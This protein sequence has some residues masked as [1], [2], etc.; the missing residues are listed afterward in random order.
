MKQL[1]LLKKY[2]LDAKKKDGVLEIKLSDHLSLFNLTSEFEEYLT[3]FHYSAIQ[4]DYDKNSIT[5]YFEVDNE[6]S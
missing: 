6:K 2:I 5:I 3:Q 1:D 4:Y